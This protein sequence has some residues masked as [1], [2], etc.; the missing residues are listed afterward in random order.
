MNTYS[1]RN[2]NNNNIYIYIYVY[3]YIQNNIYIVNNK[4][5]TNINKPH[6][7]NNKSY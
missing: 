3:I 7:N 6:D 5:I 4:I 2:N 1:N